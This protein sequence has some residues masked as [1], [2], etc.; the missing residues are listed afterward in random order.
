M[1]IAPRIVLTTALALTLTITAVARGDSFHFPS[2]GHHGHGRDHGGTI[3]AVTTI[4]PD[5]L[6]PQVYYSAQAAEAAWVVYTPLLTYKHAEGTAGG[7][8]IPGLAT[9]LPTVSADGKTYQLTLRKG[10]TYSNGQAVKASDFAYT[11]KR[12]IKLESGAKSFIAPYIE[13]AEAFDAGKSKT[14][15]GIVADD[16]TGKITIK[17]TQPYGSFANVLGLANLGLVPSGTPMTDLG[18]NP[19]PGVGP[20]EITRVD[21]A[22]GYTLEKNPRFACLRIP[23]IPTGYADKVRVRI[24]ADETTEATKVLNN[25]ADV[26]DGGDLVPAEMIPAVEAQAADRYKSIPSASTLF[27]FLNTKRAPFDNLKARQAVNTA[28]DRDKIAVLSGNTLNPDCFYLP[29][30]IVGHPSGSCPFGDTPDI[31]RAKQ[32]VAESGTAGTA[33]TVWTQAEGPRRAYAD[34]YAEMLDEIGFDARVEPIANP[35]YFG[36]VSQESVNAQ[37]GFENWFQDF[38]NPANFY[39]LLDPRNNQPG[40][41]FNL[42]NVDD[43]LVLEQLIPLSEAPA[44][45]LNSLATKWEALDR[46][47]VEQAYVAPFGE[48]KVPKFYSDRVDYGQGVMHVQFGNDFSSLRLK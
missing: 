16:R 18:Q 13:G 43:P 31:A 38:P 12:A 39:S 11:V 9:A 20:Y 47:V 25:E 26:F 36:V 27:F 28:L 29:E 34:Y 22:G 2:H 30:G 1:R 24:V 19:P 21:E 42:S 32:L 14:I 3:R 35:D 15:S 33:V 48:Q 5:S 8:L 7:T 46:Y 37:T 23:G 10:L 45:E 40:G 44:S 41:D 4:P 17:L 6:D